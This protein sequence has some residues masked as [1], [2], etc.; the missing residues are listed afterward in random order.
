MNTLKTD[1]NPRFQLADIRAFTLPSSNASPSAAAAEWKD[2]GLR[3]D[4]NTRPP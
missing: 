3:E 4:L 2:L 1:I